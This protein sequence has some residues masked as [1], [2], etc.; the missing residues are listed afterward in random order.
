[1]VV[2]VV[3]SHGV[4]NNLSVSVSEVD[5][6]H[7]LLIMQHVWVVGVVVPE[8]V[9]IIISLQMLL[10]HCNK[11]PCHS[12]ANVDPESWSHHIEPGVDWSH[13]FVV[14][15]VREPLVSLDVWKGLVEGNECMLHKCK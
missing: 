7:V 6:P 14:G 8:V 1:M 9:Q 5:V 2:R 11:Q 3:T 4:W 13:E 12:V 10:Y 15:M